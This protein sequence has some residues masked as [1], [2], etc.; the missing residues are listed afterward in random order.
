VAYRGTYL[1]L[2]DG[3][4]KLRLYGEVVDVLCAIRKYK[5]MKS[6]LVIVKNKPKI[7]EKAENC[8]NCCRSDG[9]F[10]RMAGFLFPDKCGFGTRLRKIFVAKANPVLKI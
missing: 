8:T 4:R 3:T 5:T 1:W 7:M 6:Y 10:L 9:A 2:S